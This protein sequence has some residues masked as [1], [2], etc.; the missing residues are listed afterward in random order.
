MT[1]PDVT[2]NLPANAGISYGLGHAEQAPPAPSLPAGSNSVELLQI[3]DVMTLDAD[4]PVPTEED[5]GGPY[6]PQCYVEG[7]R[8]HVEAWLVNA[9]ELFANNSYT[10]GTMKAG[11]ELY[12]DAGR[13]ISHQPNSS[14]GNYECGPGPAGGFFFVPYAGIGAGNWIYVRGDFLLDSALPS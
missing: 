7:N 14:G 6:P 11:Y 13:E 9:N 8:L 10:L 3:S 1:D 4:F 12:A 2:G 5:W